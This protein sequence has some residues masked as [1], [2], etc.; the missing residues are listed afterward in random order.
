MYSYDPNAVNLIGLIAAKELFD[1][2]PKDSKTFVFDELLDISGYCGNIN[3]DPRFRVMTPQII[4]AQIVIDEPVD[5]EGK[6][7]WYGLEE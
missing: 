4:V 6:E 7:Y 2:E 1:Y 3:H 5:K